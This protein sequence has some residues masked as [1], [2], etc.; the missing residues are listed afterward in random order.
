MRSA[1]GDFHPIVNF[2]YFSYVIG[3]SMFFMHPVMLAISAA[4]A[5]AYSIYLSGRRAAIFNFVGVFPMMLLFAIMNPLFNHRGIT[6]LF[7]LK[8]NPITLESILY[9][10]SAGLMLGSVVMWFACFNKIMTSDKLTYLFGKL[11]PSLSLV[12]SMVLRFVPRFNTQFK[13]TAE[14]QRTISEN[15]NKGTAVKIKHGLKTASIMTTWALENALDTADSMNARGYGLHG[16]TTFTLYK[17]ERRDIFAAAAV[18]ISFMIIPVSMAVGTL[19]MEY[20]PA[21][22]MNKVSMASCVLYAFHLGICF[23]PIIID[24]AEDRRWQHLQSKI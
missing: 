4:G 19:G 8:N 9:G 18:I 21:I 15:S 10:I 5:F 2:I 3:I 13:R 17:F 24:L 6:T 12:F 14:A 20:F 23:M 22:T 16:R 11:M 1:F 7:Y